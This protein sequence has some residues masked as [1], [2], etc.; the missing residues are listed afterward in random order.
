MIL[1][2]M[3]Y[4]SLKILHSLTLLMIPRLKYFPCHLNLFFL[5]LVEGNKDG[6]ADGGLCDGDGDDIVIFCR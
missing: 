3:D 2:G 1:V 4:S 6:D 5:E